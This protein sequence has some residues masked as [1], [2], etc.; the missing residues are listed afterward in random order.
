MTTPNPIPKYKKTEFANTPKMAANVGD[1]LE[2][3]NL[4]S[5]VVN[6]SELEV[7]LIYFSPID[8]HV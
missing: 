7:C 4:R 6:K 8:K 5:E 1:K 3:E 2:L